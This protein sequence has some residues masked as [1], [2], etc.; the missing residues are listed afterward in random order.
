[1]TAY[2]KTLILI[3]HG[4]TEYNAG[5]RYMG[6]G[7]DAPL[8]DEGIRRV[9]E[10]A[11]RLRK[12]SEGAMVCTGPL[13]RAKDSAAL[14]FPNESIYVE[15][16][17]TEIDFGD[18]EGK[19]A[20]ELSGDIRYRQ[21]IDSYGTLRFPNGESMEEFTD[22]TMRSLHNI[23][24]RSRDNDKTAVVCHGGCIMAIMSRLCGGNYYDYLVPNLDGYVIRMTV[25]DERIY[26]VTYDRIGSGDN[27]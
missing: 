23:I 19:S 26:D 1:M 15:E 27:T 14:I 6:R 24:D 3:R 8:S 20:E 17:L 12:L 25:N 2:N 22:R 5:G 16:D 21:W 13:K 7:I 10:N 18:F 9:K 11:D 4:V